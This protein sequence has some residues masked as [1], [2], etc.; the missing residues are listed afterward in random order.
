M[1][2]L[3]CQVDLVDQLV[4]RKDVTG[5]YLWAEP[6]KRGI[7]GAHRRCSNRIFLCDLP[8]EILLIILLQLIWIN[9]CYM[10]YL[11]FTFPNSK[12]IFFPAESVKQ[13]ETYD[14]VLRQ[15]ASQGLSRILQVLSGEMLSVVH[16][17]HSE[18]GWSE[19]RPG[20]KARE[21]T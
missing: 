4:T 9:G 8:D 2:L 18:E 21:E 5:R 10:G 6:P 13:R 17:L 12:R 1:F 14:E 11:W 20:T 16:I 7:W 3:V 15:S 19:Q